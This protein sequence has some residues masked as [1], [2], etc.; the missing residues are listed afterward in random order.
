MEPGKQVTAAGCSTRSSG[1]QHRTLDGVMKKET[2][3]DGKREAENVDAKGSPEEKVAR[4]QAKTS[5]QL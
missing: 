1:R 5:W 4:E 3:A 2:K